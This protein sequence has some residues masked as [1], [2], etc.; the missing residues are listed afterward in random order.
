[1]HRVVALAFAATALFGQ[2]PALE[3]LKREAENAKVAPEDKDAQADD[4]ARVAPLHRALRDWIESRLPADK[5]SIRGSFS[6][7]ELEMQKELQTS[8][9]VEDDSFDDDLGSN[10]RL[11]HVSVQFHE[12]AEL[13]GTL[14]VTAGASVPCGED[15]A[16]YGYQFG[17]TRIRIIEDHPGHFHSP[18]LQLSGPDATGRRVLLLNSLSVQC[19]SLWM[20]MDYSAYRFGILAGVPEKLLSVQH[21]F[22]LGRDDNFFLQ[23]D[24]LVVEFRDA[25]VDPGVHNRTQV[26]RYLFADGARRVDPIAFQPQD[27]VEEWLTRP[28]EEMQSRSSPDTAEAHARLHSEFVGG[29]YSNIVPC[30]TRPGR[31]L[32]GLDI[33]YTGEKQLPEPLPT[34]F[35]VHEL[36]QYRYQMESAGAT[37]PKGCPGHGDPPDKHPWLPPSEIWSLPRKAQ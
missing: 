5:A 14:L 19:E 16:V 1:M 3:R 26:Y 27:F 13:P 37:E 2:D 36:G 20:S 32:I 6:N 12:M 31:W 34:Y 29:E 18:E 8:G 33:A 23:P 11:G 15:G 35:L 4:F 24:G 28:W 22:W 21:G 17:A 30:Q 25:S 9:L 7:L 10:E